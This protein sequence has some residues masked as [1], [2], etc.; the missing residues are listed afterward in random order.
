MKPDRIL[1][2]C[3][4]VDDLAAAE[5]FY[6]GVLGLELHSQEPGRH[7]FFYCGESMLLLFNPAVSSETQGE[8]PAHGAKG[9]GHLALAVEEP[10]MPDWKK[11]LEQAGVAIEVDYSWSRGGR[12]L[13]FR[14]PAGNSLELATPRIWSRRFTTGAGNETPSP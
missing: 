14:D 11:R 10:T 5:E 13:Y 1:E 8:I 12:S 2:T 7:L 9:A 4:Y 3:L 6:A